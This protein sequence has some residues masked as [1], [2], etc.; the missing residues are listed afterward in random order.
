MRDAS[1]MKVYPVIKA[2]SAST[3]SGF[4]RRQNGY[5]T[6]LYGTSSF[7]KQLERACGEKLGERVEYRDRSANGQL[8]IP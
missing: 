3:A 5:I 6:T 1:L 4:D 8:S 7:Q 2:L